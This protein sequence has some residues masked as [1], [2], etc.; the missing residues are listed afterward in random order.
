M[1]PE[2][3]AL[4]RNV[5]PEDLH[6]RMDACL[7]EVRQGTGNNRT[8]EVFFRADDI[9]VPG[10]HIERLMGLFLKYNTPLNLAVV[11]AWLT[12]TRWRKLREAGASQP[13]LWCWH[14]HGWRHVNHEPD[15]KKQEFGPARS[16]RSIRKDLVRGHLRLEQLLGSDFTP[17]FTPPWNRCSKETV[18]VLWELGFT[19]LSISPGGVRSALFAEHPAILPVQ[20]DLHTRKET[21]KTLDWEKLFVEL[22]CALS[23]S[24]C[25]IV[26]HHQRMNANAFQFLEMLLQRFTS[27]P[28]IRVVRFDELRRAPY[29]QPTTDPT[30][31]NE[32]ADQR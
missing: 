20:V 8:I 14:Q 31:L 23:Q 28:D 21:R 17:V 16:R 22:K 11:P 12:A 9:A 27:I 25:G 6:K 5:L 4:W 15:G 24:R 26:I 7:A 10:A 13:H 2:I 32:Q 29:R 3:S 18:D 19:A 30:Q 1:T